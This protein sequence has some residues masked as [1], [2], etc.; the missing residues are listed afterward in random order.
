[1]SSIDVGALDI[2]VEDRP[3]RTREGQASVLTDELLQAIASAVEAAPDGKLVRVPIE[4]P[5]PGSA[6]GMGYNIKVKLAQAPYNLKVKSI[7]VPANPDEWEA[8]MEGLKTAAD[9]GKRVAEI[10]ANGT[11]AQREAIRFH[12]GFEKAKDQS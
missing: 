2:T 4:R 1:M 9:Q 10:K 6:A 5:T 8:E 11:A 3:A 7:P 12:L